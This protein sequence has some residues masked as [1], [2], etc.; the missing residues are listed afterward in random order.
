MR[1]KGKKVIFSYK[2]TWDM[3]SVISPVIYEGI[4]KFKEVNAKVDFGS[5]PGQLENMEEWEAI[6]D[7]ML[8]AF[9]GKAPDISAYGF[10][11]TPGPEHGKE[12]DKDCRVW[13]MKIVNKPE[14]DRYDEDLKIHHEKVQVGLDLFAK[15][16]QDLWW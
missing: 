6:L 2:D 12:T 13:N 1:M 16:F 3:N 15:Y 8:Y 7:K 9:A 4:K 5:Y 14:H 11:F 10:S